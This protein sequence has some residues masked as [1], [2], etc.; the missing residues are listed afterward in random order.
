MQISESIL[1]LETDII[2]KMKRLISELGDIEINITTPKS[3]YNI[4]DLDVI[5]GIHKEKVFITLK[6]SEV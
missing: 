2:P 1:K 6:I 5:H 3:S 4:K